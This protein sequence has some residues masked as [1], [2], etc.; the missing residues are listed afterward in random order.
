MRGHYDRARR[1]SPF[2]DECGNRAGI[3]AEAVRDGNMDLAWSML[4]KETRG[5]RLGVWATRYR[6][7]MQVAYR[8]GY[9]RG[10]PHAGRDAGGLSHHGSQ[11]LAT[12]G[13]DRPG[14][15]A[16]QLHRRRARLRLP[17][18][19]H[20]RGQH[21][22]APGPC[23]ERPHPPHAD[24]GRRVEGGPARLAFHGKPEG[25]QP[26]RRVQSIGNAPPR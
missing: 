3:F 15:F 22:G 2:P 23:H 14:H 1:R 6:I 18:L 25:R 12:G 21:R 17:A 16:H 10:P 13:P 24:G 4:S 7:D 19:R 9:N 5:M 20:H 26:R 8:A 11:P